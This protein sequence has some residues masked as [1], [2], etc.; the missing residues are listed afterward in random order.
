[1]SPPPSPSG[2]DASLTGWGLLR[3]R[4][5]IVAIAAIVILRLAL[6][7]LIPLTEDEAYYRLWSVR[8][9]MGYFDHP[10][11]IA[12]WIAAGRALVG[13]NPLGVRLLPILAN[14]VTVFLLMDTVR[15]LGFGERPALRAGLWY[16]A[17]LLVG[18]GAF[19]AVPDAPAALFWSTS[20]WALARAVS[21]EKPLAWWAAAGPAAGLAVLSKYSAIFLAPGVL[22]WLASSAENR[23][24]LLTPGPWIAA[25]LAV[26][27]FA[28]HVLWNADHHWASFIKQFGRVEAKTFQPEYLLELIGGQ[29]VLLNPIIA[30]FAVLAIVRGRF[31]AL[32]RPWSLLLLSA[33][34]FLAYLM[35][36]SL[37]DRV[38]AHWPAPV[39][40]ALV[41]L[42]ALGAE[43]AARRGAVE[44]WRR[45]VPALALVL[46]LV[47]MSLAAFPRLDSVIGA[48][49]VRPLRGWTEFSQQLD[50]QAAAGSTAWIGTTSYGLAAQLQD[51]NGVQGPVVQLNDRARYDYLP[52]T[53]APADLGRPGLV[54]DLA[55]RISAEQ[56]R[57]CFATVEPLP[58]IQR[59]PASPTLYGVFRVS[60]RLRSE[61]GG[62]WRERTV[63]VSAP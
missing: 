40:P 29:F 47:G 23:R 53:G 41:A 45:A 49:A 7:G 32:R 8:L 55:R 35:A 54:V 46:C 25:V 11:M 30:V 34:P 10:P 57:G 44:F 61:S 62:C 22:L 59:Y 33:L 1:M 51:R 31:E 15:R 28:P 39:Y 21:S 27:V 12:W 3:P 16:N 60:G 56:L 37:H 42:A 17:A 5:V 24:R 52:R 48:K 43:S 13:D 38:Q 14:A 2:A 6:G 50:A 58:S 26:G 63:D 36:H 19:L 18:A 9:Q 4:T 20:L